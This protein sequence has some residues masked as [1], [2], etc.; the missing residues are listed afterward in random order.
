MASYIL[1]EIFG[2]TSRV[3]ILE[4]LTERWG[5]H[6]SV[7]E[8]ARMSGVSSRA[9]YAHIYKLQEIGIVN[10]ELGRTTKFGLN[11]DDNR[12]LYLATLEDEEYLRKVKL[13]I[14]EIDKDELCHAI[15]S[16]VESETS[17]FD[18]FGFTS[19]KELITPNA[20]NLKA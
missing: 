3:C 13:S 18:R 5:E 1:K 14:E 7:K 17:Y 11:T 16:S 2:E 19:I 10:S 6:L 8:I 4:V 20:Y 12:A 15:D 9:V